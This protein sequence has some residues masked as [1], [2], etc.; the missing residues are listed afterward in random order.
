MGLG[1]IGIWQLV[2]ILVIVLVIF[3]AK[4]MRTLGGDLGHL[5]KGFKHAV[6]DIEEVKRDSEND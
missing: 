1:G 2:I 6:K 4:R 3:G 5:L